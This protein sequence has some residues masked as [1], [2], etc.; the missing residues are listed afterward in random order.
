MIGIP[1]LTA[2]RLKPQPLRLD[3]MRYSRSEE[4]Q[5]LGE[6]HRNVCGIHGNTENMNRNQRLYYCG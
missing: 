5:L 4:A 1:Q 6:I 2:K 3:L